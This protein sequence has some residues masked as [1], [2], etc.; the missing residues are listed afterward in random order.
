MN[1]DGRCKNEQSDGK[2]CS[3]L[4]Q[5]DPPRYSVTKSRCIRSAPASFCQSRTSQHAKGGTLNHQGGGP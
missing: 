1:P 2:N 5:C 4:F 3:D